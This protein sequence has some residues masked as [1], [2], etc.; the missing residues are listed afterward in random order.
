MFVNDFIN[1]YFIY[2]NCYWFT[3]LSNQNIIIVIKL[4]TKCNKWRQYNYGLFVYRTEKNINVL[5]WFIWDFL[6]YLDA[7]NVDVG[8]S[9]RSASHL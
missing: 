1:D 3:F 5:P 4:Y 7:I 6:L 9:E 8:P 2:S